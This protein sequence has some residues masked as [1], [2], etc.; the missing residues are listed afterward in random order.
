VIGRRAVL[1]GV[2]A[3]AAGGNPVQ[4]P[5]QRLTG[6]SRAGTGPAPQNVFLNPVIIV[7]PGRGVFVY[8]PKPGAGNLVASIAAVAGT[9]SYGNSYL[10]GVTAYSGDGLHA[11]EMTGGALDFL[12]TST[13]DSDF[14]LAIQI[15]G[16]ETELSFQPGAADYSVVFGTG[17]L[18]PLAQFIVQAAQLLVA[19]S[20]AAA[21]LTSALLEVQGRVAVTTGGITVESAAGSGNSI[22][23]GSIAI[24]ESSNVTGHALEVAGIAALADESA[25][26]SSSGYAALF[27]NAGVLGFV[28]GADGQAYDTG[29]VTRYTAGQSVTSTT[30]A[31]VTWG[32]GSNPLVAAGTYHVSGKMVCTMGSTSAAGEFTFTT[33]GTVSS[34]RVTFYAIENVSILVSNEITAIGSSMS[35]GTIPN[36]TAAQFF[37]DGI[38]E[39]SAAGNLGLEV[40]EGTSGDGWTLNSQSEMV[41]SPVVA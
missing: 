22:F 1:G 7:T 8:S 25:P 24:G 38:I 21:A 31:A 33:T 11:V 6:I 5:D 35:T 18:G 32:A 41:I 39:F 30:P 12:Y 10:E 34:M 26:S 16:S 9:D 37:F 20:N 27:G 4:R 36:G 23:E 17:V 14:A 2:A 29:T 15:A 19:D 40:A 3:V 13:P 28:S